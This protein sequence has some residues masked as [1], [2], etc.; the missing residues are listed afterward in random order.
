MEWNNGDSDSGEWRVLSE[1]RVNRW[2]VE[3]SGEVRAEEMEM[4]D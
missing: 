2:K 3:K 1:W 4:R